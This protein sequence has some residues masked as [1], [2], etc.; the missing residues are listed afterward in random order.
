IVDRDLISEAPAAA[1]RE[2][3]VVLLLTGNPLIVERELV[4]TFG[5]LAD[6]SLQIVCVLDG[7]VWGTLPATQSF[8]FRH[9]E[10]VVVAGEAIEDHPGILLNRAL[11][12]VAAEY[13][14]IL[15]P[16]A[17]YHHEGFQELV[18][19]LDAEPAAGLAFARVKADAPAGIA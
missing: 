12:H 9:P 6:R 5:S 13:L 15:W 8:L 10:A 18:R 19:V 1:E 14:T 16:G 7:P 17:E 2:L 11:P 4:R 3:S